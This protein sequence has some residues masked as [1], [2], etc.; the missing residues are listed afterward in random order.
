VVLLLSFYCNLL[1]T[2]W[3][4]TFTEL[5]WVVFLIARASTVTLV[6]ESTHAVVPIPEE[7]KSTGCIFHTNKRNARAG[8]KIILIR[9]GANSS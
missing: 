2:V 3:R 4:N 5:I 7:F 9:S 6:Y 8:I 1:N